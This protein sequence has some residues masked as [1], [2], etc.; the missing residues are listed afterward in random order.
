[1]S[2]SQPWIIADLSTLGNIHIF[3]EKL[4]STCSPQSVNSE[5]YNK[6]YNMLIII[7]MFS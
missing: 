1:M 3:F 2:V 6:V 5:K 4:I 7:F